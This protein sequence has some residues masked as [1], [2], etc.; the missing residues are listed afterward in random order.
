MF[1]GP[2]MVVV[3][4]W[5]KR[6]AEEEMVRQVGRIGPVVAIG[7]PDDNASQN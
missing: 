3:M 6:S 1:A 7:R 4:L 5:K 2:V